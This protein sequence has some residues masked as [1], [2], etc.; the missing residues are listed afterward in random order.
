MAKD[1]FHSN[2]VRVADAGKKGRGVFA[3]R[4]LVPGE[5]IEMAPVIMLR[6]NESDTLLKTKLGSHAFDLGRGRVGVGLGY[7]SLYNHDFK[8]NAEFEATP[9]GVQI[10][11]LRPIREGEEISLDYGWSDTAFRRDGFDPRKK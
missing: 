1:K 4:A 10:R 7:A 2:K 6:S 3:R 9:D 5:V 8:P 11:A